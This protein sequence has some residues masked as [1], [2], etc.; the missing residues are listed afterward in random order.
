MKVQ[1]RANRDP[2]GLLAIFQSRLYAKIGPN[3]ENYRQLMVRS[4]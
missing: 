4:E 2:E 3:I 1:G